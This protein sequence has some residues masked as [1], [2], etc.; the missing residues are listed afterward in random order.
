MHVSKFARLIRK[1][2]REQLEAFASV[3]L[4]R[5][6]N[7]S[8]EINLDK[9]MD[10]TDFVSDLSNDAMGIFEIAMFMESEREKDIRLDEALLRRQA[11]CAKMKGS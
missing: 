11:E 2:S 1:A 9:E 5:L 3:A 4:H 10:C 8:N 6:Y 7:D